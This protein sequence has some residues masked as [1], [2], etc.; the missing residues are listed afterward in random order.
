MSKNQERFDIQYDR[1]IWETDLSWILEIDG[2]EVQFSKRH[3]NIDYS[4]SLINAPL[5]LIAYANCEAYI[6]D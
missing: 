4:D 5:W 2:R 6:L 3:C 1:V